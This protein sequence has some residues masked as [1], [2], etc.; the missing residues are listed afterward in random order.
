MFLQAT[1]QEGEKDYTDVDEEMDENTDDEG[2]GEAGGEDGGEGG[3]EGGGEDG[4]DGGGESSDVSLTDQCNLYFNFN[5][6]YI[7]RQWLDLDCECL[8]F[9]LF[10]CLDLNL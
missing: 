9:E 8:G 10:E 3:G 6:W 5:G 4:G 2:E 1:A 7:L